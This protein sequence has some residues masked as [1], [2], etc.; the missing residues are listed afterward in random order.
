MAFTHHGY[1]TDRAEPPPAPDN[2]VAQL[3]LQVHHL[4]HALPGDHQENR[5]IL[6]QEEHGCYEQKAKQCPQEEEHRQDSGTQLDVV[7]LN[8]PICP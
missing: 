2:R 3:Q 1:E 4:F 5:L 6:T 8:K 7:T